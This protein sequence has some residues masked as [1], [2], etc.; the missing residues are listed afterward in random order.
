LDGDILFYEPRFDAYT[1]AGF[2][3]FITVT[4]IQTRLHAEEKARRLAKETLAAVTAKVNIEGFSQLE[5]AVIHDPTL[6]A[7]M[8][9]IGRLLASDPE[10]AKNLNTKKLVKFVETYPEYQIAVSIVNGEKAL[11]FDPSPQHRHQIPKLLADDYL[12]SYLTDWNYDAGSKQ[13]VLT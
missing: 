13:R 11:K 10:Y 9:Y 3:F 8:S 2:A 1:C 6:R 5:A 12:H 4:L 7:K